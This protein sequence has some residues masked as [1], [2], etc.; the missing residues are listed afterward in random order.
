MHGQIYMTKIAAH[1][2]NSE[3]IKYTLRHTLRKLVVFAERSNKTRL[4]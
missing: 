2:M 3:K 1:T 4:K